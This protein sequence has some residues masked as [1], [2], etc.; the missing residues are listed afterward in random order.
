MESDPHVA[1]RVVCMT[2]HAS[3]RR[4]EMQARPNRGFFSAR[5]IDSKIFVTDVARV[6]HP[7]INLEI[8][9]IPSLLFLVEEVL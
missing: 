1:L 8:V 3:R 7:S 6:N 5:K 9:K 2:V 4:N